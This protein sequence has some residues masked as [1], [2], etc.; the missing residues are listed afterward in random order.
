MLKQMQTKY[1][2]TPVRFLLVPCNQ[3]GD[4]EPKANSDIKAFAEQSVRLAKAGADSNVIMLAKSNL[5]GVKCTYAGD[6]ACMPTSDKCCPRNDAVYDYLL[7]NTPPGTIGWNFDKIIT[8]LDGKPYSGEKIFTG[9]D[10]EKK[11]SEVIDVQLVAATNADAMMKTLASPQ[12][13]DVA[14]VTW[15]TAACAAS[16]LL[17]VCRALRWRQ[18]S[19]E[20]VPN[21]YV[22]LIGA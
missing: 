2:E 19:E 11:L 17:A 13:R 22:H 16:L 15:L 6:D 14:G 5:N 9:P 3:F 12:S 20:E 4:Q 7:A 1:A 21:T 8:G 10:L 18:S